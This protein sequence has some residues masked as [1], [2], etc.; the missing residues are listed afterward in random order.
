MTPM[1]KVYEYVPS[2][3]RKIQEHI[4]PHSKP[5]RSGFRSNKML[6]QRAI[7]AMRDYLRGYWDRP[8]RR[9][10]GNTSVSQDQ[11]GNLMIELFGNPVMRIEKIDGEAARISVY[12][13]G[14]YDY[15]GN[16]SNLTRE[17]LNGLLD[18]LSADHYLPDN[19]KVI[20]D[21]DYGLCYVARFDQK[22]A[23]NNKYHQRIDIRCDTTKFIIEDVVSVYEKG[24]LI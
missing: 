4:S 7:N 8:G 18:A 23:L 16:P 6:T 21:N 12:D 17:R 5:S 19:V 22:A 13:G 14:R 24:K 10:M 2:T 3:A 1:D 20:M 15:E 9:D 11:D